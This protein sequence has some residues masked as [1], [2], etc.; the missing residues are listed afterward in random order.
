MNQ[1]INGSAPH[2]RHLRWG[3]ILLLLM[4]L[5]VLLTSAFW[6][7]VWAYDHVISPPPVKTVSADDKIANDEVL[8]QRINVLLLGIDDGESDAGPNEPKRTDAMIVVS[9]DT[10]NNQV[11]MISL[12]RDTRVILP[13]HAGWDKINAAYAYGGVVMAKQTV[14][15]L[16]RIPIHYYALVNWQGFIDV[17]NLIGGVDL[18]VEKDMQYDDPYA[19]L[20]IDIKKG[21]QHL[22]GEKSGEY[23]RFRK[24]EMGDIGRV[25]RQQRFLKAM[26]M[27]M[28]TL[29]NLT[30]IPQI[31]STVSQ[32]VET[33][34]NTMTVLKAASSFKILDDNRIKSGMLYGD[35]LDEGGISYWKT[36]R[37][38]TEKS[39]KEV[40]IPFMS[41]EEEAINNDP[42]VGA[43]KPVKAVQTKPKE[44]AA[45]TA[46]ASEAN[47]GKNSGGT[48]KN[49]TKNQTKKQTTNR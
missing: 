11:S 46:G 25:Q 31:L 26:I 4:L 44:Q 22:D 28:F 3:R 1:D 27:Q 8:N 32:Y 40:G 35:F 15:N 20:H 9:F 5:A 36:N 7:A 12:P 47:G 21:Y 14:A 34:M 39:M 49:T 2:K 23:V 18:F 16:L 19:N 33:D 43:E 24:D 13:G 10:R 30:K 37:Y 38:L 42:T 29:D 45:G 48:D 6:G 41:E 17:I